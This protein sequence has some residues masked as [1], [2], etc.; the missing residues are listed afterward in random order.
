MRLCSRKRM[1]SALAWL[2]LLCSIAACGPGTD[3]SFTETG[4]IQDEGRGQETSSMAGETAMSTE[5]TEESSGTDCR[6]P[7]PSEAGWEDWIRVLEDTDTGMLKASYWSTDEKILLTQEQI[8]GINEQNP[9]AV[10]YVDET[11]QKR[12]LLSYETG[13][14]IPGDTVRRVMESDF[15]PGAGRQTYL[16]GA[17]LD[18]GAWAALDANRNLTAVPETVSVIYGICTQ[19]TISYSYP[20]D[21]FI[22][23]NPSD[24]YINVN[25]QTEVMPGER[26]VLV[27]ESQD[28]AWYYALLGSVSGWIRKET[29]ALCKDAVQWENAANPEAFLVVTGNQVR[30]DD[31]AMPSAAS[32]M[33][34]PMGMRLGLVKDPPDSV[35]GR[36]TYGCYVVEIPARDENGM[37]YME[38]GLVPVSR[39]VHVG[40]LPM[41]SEEIIRQAFQ[42]LGQVYGWG[43]SFHANDCSGMVRQIFRCFGLETPRNSGAII[44]MKGLD[45]G[46]LEETLSLP[47]R[48]EILSSLVPGSLL[49]FPGHIMIYLGQRDGLSYVI[50]SCT[51]F[52]QPSAAGEDPLPVEMANSVCVNGLHMLRGNGITWLASL[53]RFINIKPAD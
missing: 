27:H 41:S 53:S 22:T 11:G 23:T 45:S 25:I 44:N 34:L 48:E 52:V 26:V 8:A 19:R 13:D 50:S 40:Y 31:T 38:T 20:T 2:L 5:W 35:G 12:Q 29:V 14:T 43:G 51:A 24:P 15:V 36:T 16:G 4:S 17:P 39:D 42:F 7:E 21:D 6:E 28:G 9:Q 33:L 18:E 10:T 47:E 1:T 30:L 3:R 46:E 49:Y 37:L 32:G